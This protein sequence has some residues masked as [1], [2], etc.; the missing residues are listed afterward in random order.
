VIPERRNLA[1]AVVPGALGGLLVLVVGVILIATG[2]VGK[3]ETKTVVREPIV[4]RSTSS[5]TGKGQTVSQIYKR[6]G[7]GVVFIQAR[8]VSDTSPF[9]LPGQGGV[10]TGSGFV[11][12][13]DGYVLTN[14]HVVEGSSD[15]SVRFTDNCDPV[16]A[17]VKGRDASSDLALLKI[18]PSKAKLDPVPLGNSSDVAVGDP[19]VAIGNPFGL[20][21]TV[22]TGIVSAVQ[23]EISAPNNFT[24]KG[25]IQTDA[26]I[27]PGNS[28]GPLLSA[29]GRVIGI[30]SQIATGGGNGSVGIGFA[31]PINLAKKA[32]P[33]LKKKGKVP[34]A[35]IGVTTT[36]VTKRLAQDLN[37]PVSKGA[38]VVA[39]RR[40]SPAA[41]AGLRAGRTETTSGLRIGGDLIVGLDDK[42][43]NNPDDLVSAVEG[44]K[45][46]DKVT[47]SYYRGTKKK[48][49]EL[50][51][52]QRPASA[53]SSSPDQGGGGGGGGGDIFPF[54]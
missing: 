7:P 31:V 29:D 36:Q 18:D 9:G 50:T 22:T 42:K 37:L 43:V 5:D 3:R 21:R 28:G 8:G 39:V 40:G 26:S 19:V 12:S 4:S 47:I 25:A 6:V 38:L 15:V 30:N 51:L 33:E 14:D 35:F 34:H 27:N 49:A 20:Q 48:S 1:A 16:K 24:I 2:A 23:R 52:A 44:K 10:A 11:I 17:E 54:P 46:G 32:V 13:K 53:G 41:K 45:P